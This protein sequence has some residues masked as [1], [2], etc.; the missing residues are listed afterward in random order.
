MRSWVSPESDR[1]GAI[2][3][4]LA[5]RPPGVIPR[6]Y[7]TLTHRLVAGGGYRGSRGEVQVQVP[8][9]TSATPSRF[10]YSYSP[11]GEIPVSSKP[12]VSVSGNSGCIA[13]SRSVAIFIRKCDPH[14]FSRSEHHGDAITNQ[15]YIFDIHLRWPSTRVDFFGNA[16]LWTF[17]MFRH[18]AITP[19]LEGI[20]F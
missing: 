18:V 11:R 2:V 3:G 14:G 13:L 7:K 16:L 17:R 20:G 6:G 10:L 12:M 15:T 8:P 4:Q 5:A 19:T 1:S 9:Y